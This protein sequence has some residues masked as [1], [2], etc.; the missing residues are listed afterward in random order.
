[1][2]ENKF[3]PIERMDGIEI[4][5]GDS[6]VRPEDFEPAEVIIKHQFIGMIEQHVTN[7]DDDADIP[8]VDYVQVTAERTEDYEY[9]HFDYEGGTGFSLR[10]PRI[11]RNAPKPTKEVNHG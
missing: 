11:V 2:K 7:I 4:S 10:M 8:G 5:T 9:I 6:A 1:M 3:M